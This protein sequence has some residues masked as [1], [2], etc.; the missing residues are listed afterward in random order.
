MSSPLAPLGAGPLERRGTS[1]DPSAH[2]SLHGTV[3]RSMLGAGAGA[4]AA[5]LVCRFAGFSV[6]TSKV[7]LVFVAAGALASVAVKGRRW[8]AGLMGGGL[9]ALGSIAA[10]LAAQWAPFSAALFG[11]AAA[12]VLGEGESAR[13]KLL[14][15]AVAGAFGYAGLHVSQVVL[16]SGVLNAL[17]PGPLAV[18]GAG[19]VAG[20]FL[21]LATAPRHLLLTPDPVEEAYAAALSRR[22]GEIHQLLERALGIHRAVRAELDARGRGRDGAVLEAQVSEQV[23]RILR[24]AEHCRR[25]DS[26]LSADVVAQLHDRM[27]DLERKASAT[28]DPSARGTYEHALQSLGEQRE[29]LERLSA[30]R[31]RVVARLHVNVALLEKLRVSLLQLRSA[32]AERFGAE[33]SPVNEALDEL[34]RELD[35]TAH[36]ISEVFGRTQALET[37][38]KTLASRID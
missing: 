11:A 26:D 38:E 19:A 4:L 9:G 33:T 30:G 34:G 18:A 24:I 14:T 25:V 2:S 28:L 35:A 37:G 15:G 21:G 17:V 32:D 23:M 10:G 36:A 3:A 20:L 22:D 5:D 13:R 16:Q 7:F 27:A 29:A 1:L 8:L 31:E 12:P 6:G